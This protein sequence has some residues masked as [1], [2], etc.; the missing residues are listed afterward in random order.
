MTAEIKQ[1]YATDYSVAAATKLTAFE[2]KLAR[3][4]QL[5]KAEGG[6]TTELDDISLELQKEDFKYIR[7]VN[8][9]IRHLLEECESKDGWTQVNSTKGIITYYRK[10]A[11]AKTHS[12]KVQGEVK[13]P[14]VNMLACVYEVDLFGKWMPNVEKAEM[15]KELSRFR[16]VAAAQF[17]L[18][19]P[20]ANREVTLL[21]YGDVVGDAVAVYFRSVTETDTLPGFTLPAPPPKYVRADLKFGGMLFKPVDETTTLVTVVFN[22]DPKLTLVPYWLLNM[23]SSKFCHYI[24]MIMRTKAAAEFAG[25][26]FEKRVQ[27]NRRVYGEIERR[28]K[29][30]LK[31]P[32]A[33]PAA[34]PVAKAD[35]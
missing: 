9:E 15:V 16:M 27:T 34:E 4:I 2:E 26:E 22:T 28:L 10:E 12:F 5:T 33:P 23:I 13:A 32:A 1:L 35:A 29:E 21:G 25:S 19:W 30:D 31:G 14:L 17:G 20:I 18:P 7:L 8:S 6:S 24:L 11:T 3:I